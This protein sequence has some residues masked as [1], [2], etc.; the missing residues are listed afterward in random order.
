MQSNLTKAQREAELARREPDVAGMKRNMEGPV[1]ISRRGAER[2][3]KRAV[4]AN[5]GKTEAPDSSP[6]PPFRLLNRFRLFR[7]LM[8]HPKVSKLSGGG[9]IVLSGAIF[10]KGLDWEINGATRTAAV[11]LFVA[12]AVFSF[13]LYISQW[14]DKRRLLTMAAMIMVAFGLVAVWYG[15]LPM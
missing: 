1:E 5:T 9:G 12:W 3:F 6:V 8:A 13:S 7:W 2:D 10:L 15:Y 14:W 4:Q 11:A